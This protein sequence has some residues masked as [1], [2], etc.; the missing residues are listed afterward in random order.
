MSF[1]N[2][3]VHTDTQQRRHK[4][5]QGND[6]CQVFCDEA[7]RWIHVEFFRRKDT[8]S[9]VAMLKRA[10]STLH[11]LSRDSAECR[12]TEGLENGRPVMHYFS[13]NESAIIARD[14]RVSVWQRSS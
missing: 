2:V 3:L 1:R 4:S 7:T 5:I 10:E 9:F 11:I 12:D 6:R 13:D 14:Q 8:K